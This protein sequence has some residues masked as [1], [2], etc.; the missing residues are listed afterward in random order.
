KYIKE[1]IEHP[2]IKFADSAITLQ[3]LRSGTKGYQGEEY[4][5]QFLERVINELF[6]QIKENIVKEIEEELMNGALRDSF[7]ENFKKDNIDADGNYLN[8]KSTTNRA[9][10]L[11]YLVDI[12]VFLRGLLK[13]NE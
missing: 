1:M 3:A 11:A 8:R 7:E 2:A 12:N 13:N 10:A 5:G 4:L 9:G 6:T